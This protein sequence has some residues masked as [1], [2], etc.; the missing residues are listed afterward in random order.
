MKLNLYRRHR[1]ECEA[2]KPEDLRSTRTRRASQRLG[3]YVLLSDPPVGHA[4]RYVLA[5]AHRTPIGLK[6]PH[7]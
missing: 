7:R 4:R 1:P 2:G 5:Q 3:S 6:A